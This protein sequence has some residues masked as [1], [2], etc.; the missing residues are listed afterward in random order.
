MEW[1]LVG[2]NG[3]KRTD[4]FFFRWK[5]KQT[6]NPACLYANGNDPRGSKTWLMQDRDEGELQE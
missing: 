2:E 5:N 4:C 6:Y 3:V 1:K